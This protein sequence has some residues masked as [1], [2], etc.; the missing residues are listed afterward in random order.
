MPA[1]MPASVPATSVSTT[2][3]ASAS[4]LRGVFVPTLTP[5]HADGRVH[6]EEAARLF[7]WLIE[8]GAAGLYPNGSTGEFA[9]L[10]DD[11]QNRLL[12]IAVDAAAGRPVLAGAAGGTVSQALARCE[13]AADRGAT[14]AAV[15]APYYYRLKPD[16]VEAFY[17]EL[18]AASPIDLLLY[19]IPLFASPIPVDRIRRLAL[20]CPRIVGIK[21][22]SG[23]A[24]VMAE[25]ATTIKPQRP[26]FTLLTGWDTQLLTM[27]RL[28]C[29][30]GT[31]ASANVAPAEMSALFEA[32]AGGDL[33]RAERIQAPVAALFD[34]MIGASDGFE[35]EFPDGFRMG[36]AVRGFEIAGGL[37]PR[38]E[39]QA[40]GLG[41]L[42][43]R[44][45]PLVDAIVTAAE[46]SPT[47]RP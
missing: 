35:P 36:A 46:P 12:E 4:P 2:P 21:D 39:A 31:H 13:A 47:R 8:Q 41:R 28:G 16:S 14:A 24:A 30:G 25:M 17:R 1:P 26:E 38:S 15:V 3:P 43:D 5:V 27:L 23:D 6:E 29:D 20:D 34:A 22:S 44:L 19:N 42:H 45:G 37:L 18:A 7:A 9:R 10:D 40:A 32:F 11:A 33:A